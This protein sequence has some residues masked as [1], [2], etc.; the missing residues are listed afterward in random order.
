M[1]ISSPDVFRTTNGKMAGEGWYLSFPDAQQTGNRILITGSHRQVEMKVLIWVFTSLNTA[2]ELNV[3]AKCKGK[4]KI[5]QSR[6]LTNISRMRNGREEKGI[7]RECRI[8]LQLLRTMIIFIYSW[9]E[10]RASRRFSLCFI[11]VKI[12]WAWEN[13]VNFLLS[14]APS[15]KSYVLKNIGRGWRR[16]AF[17]VVITHDHPRK[18]WI[19]LSFENFATR[20]K[21]FTSFICWNHHKK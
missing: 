12:W 7:P 1:W 11:R 8:Y 20:G 9:G 19:F 13:H 6:N 17:M 16:K 3:K 14:Y 5:S 21:Y 2:R 15:E 10:G 4:A 18:S